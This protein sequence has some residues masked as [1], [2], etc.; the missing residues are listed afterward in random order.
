MHFLYILYFQG[1]FFVIWITGV[2]ILPSDWQF[3]LT[4]QQSLKSDEERNC[5]LIQRIGNGRF[6]HLDMNLPIFQLV[7][8]LFHD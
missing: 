1:S 7:C 6:A 3:Y 4:D 5:F 2:K 8:T